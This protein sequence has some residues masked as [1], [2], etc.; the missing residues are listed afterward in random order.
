DVVVSLQRIILQEV[1]KGYEGPCGVDMLIDCN[2]RLRP[3]VELNL[4]RTMGM[5]QSSK[6]T[7]FA[8]LRE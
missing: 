2:G 5:I 3:F 8:S 1:L 6:L 4:R 7:P